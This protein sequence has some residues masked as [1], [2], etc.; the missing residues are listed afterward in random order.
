MEQQEIL[1]LFERTGVILHGGEGHYITSGGTHSATLIRVDKVLQF[2]PFNRKLAYE[3]VRHFL[4]LDIHVV[5]TPSVGG[6]PAAVE[7]GRQLEARTIFID[8]HDTTKLF[9]GF[10]MHAGERVVIVQDLL[11]SD[12]ELEELTAL[13]RHFDARLIGVGSIVDVRPSRKKFT[14]KDVTAI[15]LPWESFPADACP[16]CAAGSPIISPDSLP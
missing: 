8:P 10:M 5:A 14:V 4:E 9:G 2:P 16:F 1:D 15:R 13:V 12:R 11:Q 7:V 3:I 6:I